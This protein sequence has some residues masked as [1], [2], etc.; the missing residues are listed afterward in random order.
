MKIQFEG[1]NFAAV[2]T[3]MVDFLSNLNID[4][5]P[6]DTPVPQPYEQHDNMV[7]D[8]PAEEP[9]PEPTEE[10]EG[11]P[12][13]PETETDPA[14][15][16]QEAIDKLMELYNDG[17]AK[18]VKDLLTEFGVKKFGEIPEEKG[19]DLLARAKEIA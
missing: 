2:L 4:I 16:K 19:P 1:D 8:E 5:L 13:P 17:M 7:E 10:P 12:E 15:A 6:D 18:E 11:E 9:E 14:E 3:Q